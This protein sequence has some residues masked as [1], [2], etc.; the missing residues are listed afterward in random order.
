MDRADKMVP[1]YTCCRKPV[2][3]TKEF[4]LFLLQMAALNNLILFKKYTTDQ[5]R[6]VKYYAFK[7]FTLNSMQK[8]TDP[9]G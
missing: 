4:R 1:H 8:L 6:K 7:N 5:N 3:R 9:A 2:K